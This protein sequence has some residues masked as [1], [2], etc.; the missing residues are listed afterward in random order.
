MRILNDILSWFM[1]RRMERIEHFKA[2]PLE[3]QNQ[4]FHELIDAA[5]RTEWGI[6]YGYSG[7]QTVREFQ[8][9]V[10]V[11]SYEVLF[12]YIERV[13]KGEQNVLWPS[14]I[15]WF[16]KSSGTTNARSKFLPMSPESLEDCHYRG[17]KDM[18]T[19]F[20][21]NR[22]ETAVFDGKALSIGGSLQPNP[23]NIDLMAGDVSAII[24]KNLPAWGEY[25]R[26]PPIEVALLD[27]WEEKV[28]RM[29]EITCLEN[30]TSILGVPTWV[31]I[32]MDRI[33][34]Q[35]RVSSM[36]DVWPNFEVFVHG[37]VA[38]QPYRELFQ[39]KYFP[40]K[41][42]NYLEIYN[43]SEGCFAIQDD[44]SK[45]GEMLLML[46][47]GVFYEFVPAEKA[48]QEHPDAL[49]LDQVQL[50]TNYALVIST[51]AGLWRYKIGDT[52]KFTCLNP[53]RV[54]VSGRTK[55]FINAF[56]EELIVDNADRAITSACEATG[57]VLSEYT[58]GPIYMDNGT[59]GR[60]EWIIEFSEAPADR[61]LFEHILDKTLRE[62]NSD[63]DAKRHR[64]IAL[65]R[66]IVHHVPN[67]T[68]YNW[69][70]RRGKLG[71][72]HKVPRLS[73]SRE[74]LDDILTVI[75][76]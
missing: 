37:A 25:M 76:T 2:F 35:N 44:L 57:A 43:A 51:N 10:P 48:D 70:A 29:A 69:M 15:E 26:T 31:V 1:K 42:V 47:Y 3:V 11:S 8:E 23:H 6:K 62:V 20:V 67:G 46:D 52:I 66:P 71:G 41:A 28:A 75:Q 4:V 72:Q 24:M 38:F 18:M 21:Q 22:P 34:E 63:Y 27:N 16:S 56:G 5:K 73:N 33:M 39:T 36:L 45:P 50:D 12:P 74:Y 61:S 54:K 53:F 32:L 17:G 68:F 58:A 19:L 55:H 9:R 13:L 40:S 30:V 14:D 64:D 60:H 65:V 59:R 49:T 7:I